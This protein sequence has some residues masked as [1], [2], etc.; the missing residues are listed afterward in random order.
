MRYRNT[1]GSGIA[2]VAD[3]L[4][5][6]SRR[7]FLRRMG[8]AAVATT[9]L[10]GAGELVGLVPASAQGVSKNSPTK[11]DLKRL[12]AADFSVS[13]LNPDNCCCILTCTT[14]LYQCNYGNPCNGPA[15]KV[16]CFHCSGCN[17]NYY[18]CYNMP[19]GTYNT[20]FKQC[21]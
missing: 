2:G 16:C 11:A 14:A 3:R 18:S 4:G 5:V 17:E 15:G 7:G 1:E 13:K 12:T 21:P 20:C 19:C 8:L 6:V 9:A 10:A